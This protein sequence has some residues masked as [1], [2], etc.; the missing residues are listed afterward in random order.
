VI[1]EELS[2][3]ETMRNRIV[4]VVSMYVMILTAVV[5]VAQNMAGMDMRESKW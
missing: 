2:I 1:T 5:L 3:T 4:T